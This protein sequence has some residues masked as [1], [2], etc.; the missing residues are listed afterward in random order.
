MLAS[1]WTGVFVLRGGRKADGDAR[2]SGENFETDRTVSLFEFRAET[3]VD[4][5]APDGVTADWQR[6]LINSLVETEPNAPLTVVVNWTAGKRSLR[7]TS[8]DRLRLIL[9]AWCCALRAS[10]VTRK[11]CACGMAVSVRLSTSSTS[12]LPYG[13]GSS[14]QS[15]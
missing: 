11:Q 3:I 4:T 12:C 13:S 14:L 10:S 9:W 5:F 1:G 15:K 8:H 2:E 6:F 7:R